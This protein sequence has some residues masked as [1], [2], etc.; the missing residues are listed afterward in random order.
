MNDLLL[1]T[2]EFVFA[3]MSDGFNENIKFKLSKKQINENPLEEL[4]LMTLD[5]LIPYLSFVKKNK[6]LFITVKSNPA[7]F[8][9]NEIFKK[10]YDELF[11]PILDRFRV[12]ETEK[13]YRMTYYLNGIYFMVMEWVKGGCAED[14]DFIANLLINC[15]ESR[16][17]D[18]K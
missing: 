9:S 14:I 16:L 4:K 2:V 17:S 3:Q 1:E 13:R 7:V 15:V 6:T 8:L 12:P 5:Y 11:D 10:L 18:N